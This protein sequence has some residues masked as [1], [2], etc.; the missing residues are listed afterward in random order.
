MIH[1]LKHAHPDQDLTI[2]GLAALQYP[3][4]DPDVPEIVSA[5]LDRM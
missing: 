1:E 5:K 2:A 4:I 3:S